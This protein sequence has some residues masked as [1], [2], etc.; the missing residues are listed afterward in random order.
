MVRLWWSWN[1]DVLVCPLRGET[2]PLQAHFVAIYFSKRKAE[3]DNPVQGQKPEKQS[4]PAVTTLEV[5]E[6]Q[7][8]VPAWSKGVKTAPG[9]LQVETPCWFLQGFLLG[10]CLTGG[11]GASLDIALPWSP[12]VGSFPNCPLVIAHWPQ[13]SPPHF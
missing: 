12:Q 7:R 11:G 3:S 2:G 8:E 1:E 10:A 5:K 6:S 9:G 13:L 4:G